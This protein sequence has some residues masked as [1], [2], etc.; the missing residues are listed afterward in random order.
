MVF[1]V[2]HEQGAIEMDGAGGETSA[3]IKETGLDG[4]YFE[5]VDLP[6]LGVEFKAVAAAGIFRGGIADGTAREEVRGG[7]Q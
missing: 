1:D 6:R 2:F 7:G 4:E 3:V 5:R